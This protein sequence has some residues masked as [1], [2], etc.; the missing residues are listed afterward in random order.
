MK[1]K[2][3]TPQIL[4]TIVLPTRCLMLGASANLTT[5]EALSRSNS[6]DWDDDD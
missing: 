1:K 6:S 4:K 5:S 3:T 2:Y